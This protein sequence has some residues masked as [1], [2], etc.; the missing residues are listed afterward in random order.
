[1]NNIC[2][3]DGY[4]IVEQIMILNETKKDSHEPDL[5]GDIIYGRYQLNENPEQKHV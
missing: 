1:M 3:F 5:S 4:M 2:D